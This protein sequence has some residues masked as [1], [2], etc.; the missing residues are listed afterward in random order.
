MIQ[1][2][3]LYMR[4]RK[5]FILVFITVMLQSGCSDLF[6]EQTNIPPDVISSTPVGNGSGYDVFG[7]KASYREADISDDSPDLEERA[8]REF[9]EYGE[10]NLYEEHQMELSAD[11]PK[12][13]VPRTCNYIAL[14]NVNCRASDY[15]EA[16]LIAIL[17]KG[18]EAKLQYI[19]PTFTHGKFELPNSDQCWI[20]L[21]LMEGPSNPL[22]LCKI[23]VV[24][25]PAQREVS[26]SD[27]K[28]PVICSR[29]LD[30]QSCEAADGTWIENLASP[31]HCDCS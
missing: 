4:I 19:N 1:F 23:Y 29:E 25:A 5:S 3:S 16:T 27:E 7:R 6:Q 10:I 30:K 13:S 26:D 22:D 18:E 8:S 11:F 24:D 31:P 20:I 17:M 28:T 15:A 14:R 12:D 21:S 2:D 9:T